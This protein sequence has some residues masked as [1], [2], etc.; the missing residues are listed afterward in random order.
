MSGLYCAAIFDL[1]D[2][3]QKLWRRDASD[4]F[5]AEPWENIVFQFAQNV[6]LVDIGPNDGLFVKPFS[7][8]G[9]EC[10]LGIGI[11]L[12]AVIFPHNAWVDALG[13]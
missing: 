6:L 2:H 13:N 12:L 10:V 4:Y 11:L 7:G 8:H 9:L 1:S 5:A 3:P